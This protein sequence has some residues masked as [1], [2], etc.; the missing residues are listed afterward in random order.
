MRGKLIHSVEITLL[1]IH[2]LLPLRAVRRL[3]LLRAFRT[4]ARIEAV[5]IPEGHPP[6]VAL[7]GMHA[8]KRKIH[9]PVELELLFDDAERFTGNGTPDRDLQNIIGDFTDGVGKISGS[10][11][12]LRIRSFFHYS[13]PRKSPCTRFLFCEGKVLRC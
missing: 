1:T 8:R 10:N 4:R 13:T 11:N 5:G 12:F 9:S 3:H 2:L 6:L 7:L